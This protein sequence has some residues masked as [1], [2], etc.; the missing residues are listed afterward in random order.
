VKQ[1]LAY[2]NRFH[3]DVVIDLVCYR[4][5]GHNEGDEPSFTQPQ[6]YE[7]IRRRPSVRKLY[8]HALL[9]RGILHREDVKR[10]EDDLGGQ[11]ARALEV[12]ESRPPGPDEPYEPRGPWLG[13]ARTLADA[14][15]PETGVGIEELARLAE[16]IAEVPDGFA[17]HPKLEAL[18]QKRRKVI[19]EDGEIDWALAE[20]FAFGSLLLEGNA[21]RLSGQD[22]TRGTFSHRHAGV[23]DQRT[24]EEF[25]PLAHLSPS[26][27]RFEV[28]DSLLSEA[29]VLGFEYGYSLADPQTLV[30]WEAQFGDFANGAQVI[31]DQFI[32]SAHVKW[33]RM[34]GL[35]MLLPHGYEGQGPEHSSARIERYL[36][37]CAD[38]N[39]QV[40]NCT[41]PAQYFHVLRRQM[42][43]RWRT[44]LV[45]FTPKSLLRLSRATSRAEAL[46]EGRFQCVIE[47]PRASRNPQAVRRVVFS[48]GKV[49]YDLFEERR[50]LYGEDAPVALIRVEQLYPWPEAELAETIA[51]YPNAEIVTWCQE[52]PANMGGWTFVR[53]RIQSVLRPSQRLAYAGRREAASPAA[54]SGRIH[55]QEQAAL[56][57]SALCLD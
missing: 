2:R 49:H 29:A 21:V 19:S 51:R 41:T 34:S 28:Y 14:D 24:G 57:A 17:V 40:V 16:R 42:A 43:R 50:G 5:H 55:K 37:S 13:F 52:E 7:K 6:L 27:G 45:I 48:S 35:V 25:L 12:I 46:A 30:L 32:C 38:D 20:A 56:V 10:I 31:I 11:L 47:D 26:Q 9:E 36:Q 54:G 22:C 23:V 18:L 3:E 33:Q 15:D 53:E 39:L 44:P 1:A 4:R 8:T